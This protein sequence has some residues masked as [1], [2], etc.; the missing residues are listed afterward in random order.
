MKP[1][2]P[3]RLGCVDLPAFPLQLLLKRHPEWTAYPAAVV[4][5]NKPQSLILW[6]NEKARQL[7]VLPGLR[8]AAALSLASGLRAAEVS[9]A[10]IEKAVVE[11]TR[12]L[13]R[14]TPEVEPSAQE[15]G[16]F[17]LNGKGLKS[18]YSSPRNWAQ[19]VQTSVEADAF[20]TTVVI[21]FTR[22]GT[23]AVARAAKGIVVFR[24]PAEERH[25]AQKVPLDRLDLDPDF[26][27]TL[28][29]LGIKTV[30]DLLSL[31]A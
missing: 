31:P 1:S 17:W 24:D 27:D 9:A 18:L 4:A 2:T 28:F 8:Y 11:L 6:V 7:G 23:Y 15:P 10:E 16:V 3:G 13:M 5:E 22:F 12:R 20:R 25:A 14:F 21:G 26:R 19:A 29:K 30:G